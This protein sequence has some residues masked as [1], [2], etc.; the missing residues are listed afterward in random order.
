[1]TYNDTVSLPKG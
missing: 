1:M